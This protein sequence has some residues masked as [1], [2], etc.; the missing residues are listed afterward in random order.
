M[1]TKIKMIVYYWKNNGLLFK[2]KWCS[3]SNLKQYGL[4]VT[5]G[6][7]KFWRKIGDT[8]FLLWENN[9]L[10]FLYKG[11]LFSFELP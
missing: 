5:A 8:P 11:Q 6:S 3:N 1:V 2:Q 10:L 4:I 9:S 7:V